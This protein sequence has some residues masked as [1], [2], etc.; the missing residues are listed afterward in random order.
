M[1]TQALFP[2]S[3]RLRKTVGIDLGTTNSVIALLDATD[4]TIVTGQ[5]EQGR[6]T[7]PSLVGWHNEHNRLVAGRATGERGRVS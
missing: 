2:S 1:Q 4:S 6:R 7:F 3:V 5:D